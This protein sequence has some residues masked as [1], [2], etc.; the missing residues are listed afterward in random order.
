MIGW[1]VAVLRMEREGERGETLVL[2]AKGPE[3]CKDGVL[4]KLR[5]WILSPF[6][7]F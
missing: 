1:L 3:R 5:G 7:Y 6:Y 2:V 4:A